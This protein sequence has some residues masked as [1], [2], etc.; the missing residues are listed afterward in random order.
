MNTVTLNK[1]INYAIGLVL[2]QPEEYII[3]RIDL[4]SKLGFCL[5]IYDNSPFNEISEAILGK[6]GN[7]HY[8]TAGKNV[9]VARSLSVLCATAYAHGYR[10]LLFL[11][12][13]TRVS[14][15]TL[16]FINDYSLTLTAIEQ[17]RYAAMVFSGKKQANC[18]S[19]DA[20]FAISSGS[21]FTLD[22]LRR[23]GWHNNRYFVDCVDYEFCLRSIHYGYKIRIVY[24]T[25]GFD[26]VTE[27]P[28]REICL[29]GKKLLIRRY[30]FA[31]IKDAF[32]AYMR[33]L[34]YTASIIRPDMSVLVIRSMLI[35]STGQLIARLTVRKQ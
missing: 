11:D 3:K 31:R 12:Q 27:Q 25:P 29:F 1:E 4:M 8:V 17:E 20:T 23:I 24:N 30:A 35:Y 28:D 13:D 32:L 19:V 2:Y 34:G 18:E 33:L 7:I 6:S 16:R 14:D 26:H 9:G 15:Q 22:I 21:L 5:Y 10:K